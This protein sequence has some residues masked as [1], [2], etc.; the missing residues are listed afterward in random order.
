M[1]Y[2]D[3]VLDRTAHAVVEA[4][5]H[6]NPEYCN[7]VE[8]F[9]ATRSPIQDAFQAQLGA[10]HLESLIDRIGRDEGQ[11]TVA[12]ANSNA[13]RV[14]WISRDKV[15]THGL[16]LRQHRPVAMAASVAFLIG[17]VLGWSLHTERLTVRQPGP[18]L[19]TFGDGRLVAQGALQALL[20]RAMSGAPTTVAAVDGDA[21]ELKATLTFR[22]MSQSPCRRYEISSAAAGRFA[23]YACRS[24][25]G[26]WFVNAHT[27]L[28]TKAAQANGFA[29]AG[30]D[31]DAVLDAAIRNVMDGDVYQSK[32]EQALIASRWNAARK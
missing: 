18:L 25:E 13:A 29:P 30:G 7:K 32:E 31:G 19:V 28:A 6:G 26:Q 27:S 23:G 17:G 8:K 5:I 14:V 9:R 4:A 12:A 11:P 21:W 10:G 16:G 3:G 15:K 22:S 20:E 24:S 1:A 2:A